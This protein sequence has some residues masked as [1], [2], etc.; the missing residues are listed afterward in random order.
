V[1]YDYLVK[2]AMVGGDKDKALVIAKESIELGLK[3]FYPVRA[4]VYRYLDKPELALADY[5]LAIENN[6]YKTSSFAEAVKLA[7]QRGDSNRVEKY[8]A[9]IDMVQKTRQIN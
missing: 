3:E 9:F 1:T 2:P 6:I 8:Q 4:D 5:D 7:E